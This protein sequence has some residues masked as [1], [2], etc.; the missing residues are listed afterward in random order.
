MADGSELALSDLLS[1]SVSLQTGEIPLLKGGGEGM[2]TSEGDVTITPFPLTPQGI[3]TGPSRPLLLLPEEGKKDT[4]EGVPR[5]LSDLYPGVDALFQNI[6]EGVNNRIGN[7]KPNE[8]VKNKIVGNRSQKK[9]NGDNNSPPLLKLQNNIDQRNYFPC[10]RPFLVPPTIS[11]TVAPPIF[12]TARLPSPVCPLKPTP[13]S[14]VPRPLTRK[15]WVELVLPSIPTRPFVPKL[16][17]PPLLAPPLL[18]LDDPLSRMRTEGFKLLTLPVEDPDWPRARRSRKKA[19]PTTLATGR[20]RKRRI[21]FK[22]PPTVAMDTVPVVTKYHRKEKLESSSD[23]TPSSPVASLSNKPRP[24]SPSNEPHPTVT[25]SDNFRNQ[26]ESRS[27][28][29]N[30]PLP[31]KDPRSALGLS[32][33]QHVNISTTS[34]SN[35]D[36]DELFIPLK[37]PSLSPSPSHVSHTS[38]THSVTPLRSPSSPSHKSPSR[39][40]PLSSHR[41]PSLSP[42]LV[43]TSVAIQVDINEPR[44]P[45]EK[46]GRRLYT[47]VVDIE[48]KDEEEVEEEVVVVTN[49]V[50]R[51]PPVVP[52]RHDDGPRCQGNGPFDAMRQ[53][54]LLEKQLSLLEHNAEDMRDD[55]KTS[56]RVRERERH[57]HVHYDCYFTCTISLSLPLSDSS[58]Y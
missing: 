21:R 19:T 9:I 1:S 53:F 41:S 25:S 28:P 56:R 44:P 3:E 37:S 38:P 58:H 29:S 12:L 13:T 16:L 45:S 2:S 40:S 26:M 23:E 42:P 15:E 17:P 4:T 50:A 18:R 5:Q 7:G 34:I 22:S 39:V 33:I 24:P 14:N 35:E 32:S 10:Y 51:T 43:T 8:R 49:N 20:Q 55:F 57:V 31:P 54:E 46:S 6:G 27:L 36:D 47:E 48:D 30:K 11:S 52:R